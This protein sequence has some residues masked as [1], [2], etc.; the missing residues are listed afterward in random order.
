MLKKLSML[1]FVVALV[2]ACASNSAK[3]DLSSSNKVYFDFDQIV[4]N[5][6]SEEALKK[7]VEAL[8][9]DTNSKILIEGYADVRGGAKYNKC[10]A[11]K[12]A[13]TVKNYLVSQGIEADR[14][15]VVS[16]GSENQIASENGKIL[17]KENRVAIISIK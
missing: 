14:I 15:E 4:P 2:S 8:K 7:Q 13:K 11:L 16:H 6:T 9:A 5:T 17:Y 10:L 1:L 12:R 3:T